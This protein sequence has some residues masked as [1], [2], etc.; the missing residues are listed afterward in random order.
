M[1]LNQRVLAR[2]E[3]FIGCIYCSLTEIY[4]FHFF[5]FL[6]QGRTSKELLEQR[7]AFAGIKIEKDPHNNDRIVIAKKISS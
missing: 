5:W 3:E 7:G 4:K 1:G 2:I 6:T